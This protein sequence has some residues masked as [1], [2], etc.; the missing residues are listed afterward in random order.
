MD[1]GWSERSLHPPV[2]A[3]IDSDLDLG[4][5]DKYGKE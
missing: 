3:V 4:Q 1:R 2:S 5:L